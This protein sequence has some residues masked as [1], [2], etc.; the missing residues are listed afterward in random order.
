MRPLLPLVAEGVELA[1]GGRRILGPLDLTIDGRGVTAVIGPNGSG[2]TSL[3]RLLH[4]LERPRRGT[5][6]FAVPDDEARR[7]QAFVF[8]TP[9]LM[10]RT[11]LDN[12]AYPLR[13]AGVARA[14][15]RE[16]AEGLAERFGLAGAARLPASVLSGGERQKLA[17]ARA[18]ATSP[19]LLFLDEPT[20]SLDGRTTRQ[21]EGF[22]ADAGA[23]GTR[24]VLAT[25]D[26]GQARRLA[27]EVVFLHHGTVRE[28]GPAGEVLAR[29]ATAEAAAFVRGD[30]VE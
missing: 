15:A 20:A 21:I 7:R 22:L 25:H 28:R 10:R 1:K 9:V 2:K 14:A 26:L 23:S 24:I 5:V 19:D 17:L 3:L 4:G 11:V 18:L 29:P 6:R 13:L 12:I 8:Q 27:D 16:R 30:I